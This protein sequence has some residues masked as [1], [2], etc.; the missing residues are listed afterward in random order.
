[1]NVTFYTFSK[2]QKSTARP[3]SGGTSKTV[4]LK[5][6][7]SILRPVLMMNRASYDHDW[8]YVYI[9]DFGRYYRVTDTVYDNA[10]C[11]V[12]L[13]VDRLASWKTQI[14]SSS[15]YVV[16]SASSYDGLII[17]RLYPLKA[18]EQ[19]NISRDGGFPTIQAG[20]FVL[21][22]QSVE[23][24]IGAVAY[25]AVPFTSM[26]YICTRLMNYIVNQQGWNENYFTW[27]FQNAVIKPL[28]YIVSCKWFPKDYSNITFVN[29]QNVIMISNWSIAD[30]TNIKCKPLSGPYLSQ[31]STL[32]K[33]F[34]LSQHPQSQ[35][36]GLY[37]NC[38]PFSR[39]ELLWNPFGKIPIDTS[40]FST[41]S[42]LGVD[43][44][45]DWVTGLGE[46]VGYT[47]N[48][49][50]SMLPIKDTVFF[51]TAQVGVDIQLTQIITD[52]IG[53][54]GNLLQS[55]MSPNVWMGALS[56]IGSL[57]ELIQPQSQSVGT[58][59]SFRAYTEVP[60]L[61][62]RFYVACD[63][64]NTHRG[65]PLMQNK[66]INTLSGFIKCESVEIDLPA[67]EEEI[68]G[69]TSDMEGGFYYE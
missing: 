64:D 20:T 32:H 41:S 50:A 26:A 48:S 19:E 47:A 57:D 66:T 51:Q 46:L 3:S 61:I 42:H 67:T 62:Q 28:D 4:R 25:Y 45:W 33:G 69:I 5:D 27:A 56:A 15:Q 11:E 39:A 6:G 38:P 29:E 54:A 36:R 2:D 35:D 30:G 12:H 16:R 52:Y 21:G 63:D 22:V 7:C 37:M 60:K 1:M 53:T 14:G 58:M 49:S 68:A 59:G 18:Y 34:E 40:L 65:R 55:A 13:N 43:L 9:S 23:A 31:G 10:I 44:H 17:D 24:S 8:N